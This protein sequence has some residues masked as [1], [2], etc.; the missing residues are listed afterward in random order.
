MRKFVKTLNHS[1]GM[2]I[3]INQSTQCPSRPQ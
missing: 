3:K 1:K 2:G